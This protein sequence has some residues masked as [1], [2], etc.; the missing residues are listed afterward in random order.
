MNM[1]MQS[2][3][4][5]DV[6][7]GQQ[8]PPFTYELSLLRLVAFVRATGLY[9]YVHFD[10][11]YA[12]AVGARDVFIATPHVVG[13]FSRLL[14]DWAG[15][16][17]EVR[18]ITLK[19]NTQSCAGDLLQVSG[20]VGRVYT[21]EDGEHLVDV[22]DMKIGHAHSANAATA[23]ATLAL[24][25]RGAAVRA[26]RAAPA[27]KAPQLQADVPDF[28]RAL[29]GTVKEGE[30]EPERPLTEDEIHLWCECLEDWNPLY[31]DHAYARKSR[32]GGLIAPPGGL[33]HGAASSVNAGLGY[34]K[35]GTAVP[36]PVREGLTGFALLQ[37]LRKDMI[38]G[39]TP[40]SVPGYPEVAVTVARSEYYRP[41]RVGDHTRTTQE[42][43][44]CSGLKKTK[45]G[46]GH[47]LTWIRS[48]YNQRDELVRTF[49]LTGF[50][51][52]A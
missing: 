44:D 10:R 41:L 35:P 15:P 40:F 42:I 33:F 13:L 50:Y 28:V 2:L 7:E 22:V 19:M 39:K 31:W 8:L 36:A 34:G 51:Y 27:R 1:N 20:H 11:D 46:E 29:V 26:V 37:A 12:R 18:S 47:F 14:T 6:Q 45:L 5:E 9:D 48:V 52:H 24:P 32:H 43:V 23:T 30:P 21:G 38:A 25:T 17:A 49:T 4:W 16:E 3:L